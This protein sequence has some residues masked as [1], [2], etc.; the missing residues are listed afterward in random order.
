MAEDRVQP[1]PE[2]VDCLIVGAGIAGLL[3]ARMLARAGRSVLV[4]DKGRHVGGRMATRRTPGGIQFDHGAQFFTV[5]SERFRAITEEW[6]AAGVIKEWGRGFAGADLLPHNDGHPRYSG[7]G[8]MSAVAGHVAREL[9]VR[10]NTQVQA[11]HATGEFWTAD[12]EG[13]EA[14]RARDLLLTPP[15]PQSLALLRLELPPPARDALQP[16]AYEPCAALL[17]SIELATPLPDPGAVQ[18][19]NGEPI[20]WIADNSTKGTTVRPGAVTIHA[21]PEYTRQTWD[22]DADTVAAELLREA[23]KYLGDCSADFWQLHRWR[24]SRPVKLHPERCLCL[25]G[26][27]RLVFAGDA[28]GEPRVEGAALSGLA[29]ADW[30]V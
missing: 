10:S 11:I 16:I 6:L 28:F 17:A 24:Y 30:L 27:P 22:T 29:A 21:G 7:I 9:P 14:V 26:P 3:A 5:R 15:V 1:A 20:S 19:P 18:I 23:G 8:G 2:P 13:G 12:L 4:V 25:S